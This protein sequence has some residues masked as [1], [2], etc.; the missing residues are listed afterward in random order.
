MGKIIMWYKN[1]SLKRAFILITCLAVI[2][3]VLL[4]I[5]S[6]Y[7]LNN[8]RKRYYQSIGFQ[9]SHHFYN[10]NGEEVNFIVIEMEN[11]NV[12]G[13]I[14][15]NLVL[16]IPIPVF[17]LI[18]IVMGSLFYNTKLKVPIEQLSF[19]VNNISKR[20][21]DFH[22]NYDSKD[23]MGQLCQ[24]FEVMREELL[25]RYQNEW[26]MQE[27]RQRVNRAFAHDVRTPITIIKGHLQV[28][29]NTLNNKDMDYEMVQQ[30]VT[31]SLTNVEKIEHYLQMMTSVSQLNDIVVETRDVNLDIFFNQLVLDFSILTDKQNIKLQILDQVKKRYRH[32]DTVI[33]IRILEN[34]IG[35]G[36]RFASSQIQIQCNEDGN[37]LLL[38]VIDDGIGFSNEAIKNGLKPFYKDTES[39]EHLGLGLYIADVLSKKLNGLIV[40]KNHSIGGCV[41][42]EISAPIVT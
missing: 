14:L 36:I 12:I 9:N 7:M 5:F 30:T 37:V 28:L 22:I 35:N 17:I 25:C 4:S 39:T 19:G 6:M 16:F 41:S 33:L 15:T 1:L 23:E 27:E 2:L 20:Q 24:V 31:L 8:V 21:L 10:N 18:M 26:K 42:L 11:Q 40:I 13:R 32:F 3:T 29:N 34:I 38:D